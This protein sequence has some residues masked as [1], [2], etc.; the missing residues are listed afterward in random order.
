MQFSSHP[1][2][3]QGCTPVLHPGILSIAFFRFHRHC[4]HPHSAFHH[5]RMHR[6]SFSHL[7]KPLDWTHEVHE[8]IAVPFPPKDRIDTNH[9]NL[10]SADCPWW[11]LHN[12][13]IY[14]PEKKIK[15]IER[16]MTSLPAGSILI[17]SKH[18]HTYKYCLPNDLCLYWKHRRSW[19]HPVKTPDRNFQILL[20]Q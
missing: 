19:N 9:C 6:Q 14:C 15:T 5:F 7:M 12:K 20:F 3:I 4:R 10:T 18:S 13:Y 1:A 2:T 8:L 16:E 17:F 11:F